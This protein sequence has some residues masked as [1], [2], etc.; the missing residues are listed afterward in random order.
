MFCKQL[1]HSGK[2]PDNLS[3]GIKGDAITRFHYRIAMGGFSFQDYRSG[4]R[5]L[6][7]N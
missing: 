2:F 7:Q 3:S 5:S 4:R 1:N 6:K